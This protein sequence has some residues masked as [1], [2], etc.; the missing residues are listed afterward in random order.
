[1]ENT[2]SLSNDI[3]PKKARY[4]GKDL[5]AYRKG[6]IYLVL[7]KEYD[8]YRV[9]SELEESYLLPLKVLSFIED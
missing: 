6:K 8:L 5:V 1:M 3:Y 9:E 4:I 7:S 2:N